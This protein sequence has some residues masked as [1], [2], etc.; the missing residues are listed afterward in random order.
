M[1]KLSRTT[2][3]TISIE[4]K[5]DLIMVRFIPPMENKLPSTGEPVLLK[6]SSSE[7]ID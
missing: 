3:T 1:P 4:M 2:F 6:T 7:E 5:M